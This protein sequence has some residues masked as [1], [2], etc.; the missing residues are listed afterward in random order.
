M[1]RI[2]FCLF[3]LASIAIGPGG[4]GRARASL[5]RAMSLG[6]LTHSADRIVVGTVLSVD[7]SWDVQHRRILST[8]EVNVEEN[9][10]GLT[11]AS[12][13]ITI[14]QPGGS[15]GELEMT[16]HGMPA[17]SAG[18]RAVLFLQGQR[19]FQVVGMGQG[20]RTLSWDGASNRWLAES[21]DTEGVVE[22]GPGA[23]LRQVKRIRPVSLS[24]LHAQVLRIIE[25]P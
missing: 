4:A 1:F 3:L 10:K 13:R 16:V 20:K 12:Q 11:A 25:N 18:E 22:V 5:L 24:D 21:P 9:W 8:I 23:S 2:R 15:V 19:R 7:A 6:E 14:V 17:F